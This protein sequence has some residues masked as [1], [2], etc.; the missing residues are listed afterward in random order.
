MRHIAKGGKTGGVWMG[1]GRGEPHT[2]GLKALQMA[3]YYDP[4]SSYDAS[5]V[6]ESFSEACRTIGA[7]GLQAMLI[8]AWL[9]ICLECWFV[10]FCIQYRGWLVGVHTIWLGYWRIT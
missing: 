2:G 1:G 4:Y 8:Q 7:T 3:L 9:E 10:L 6:M 5:C